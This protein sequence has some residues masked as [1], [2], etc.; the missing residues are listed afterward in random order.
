MALL[1]F[2]PQFHRISEMPSIS[3]RRIAILSTLCVVPI[4]AMGCAAASVGDSTGTQ[5]QSGPQNAIQINSDLPQASVGSQ[6]NAVLL[7]GAHPEA[8]ASIVAGSLP[9]G[10]RLNVT[11]TSIG[12]TPAT[13]GVYRFLVQATNGTSN[14]RRLQWAQVIVQGEATPLRV[15]LSPASVSLPPGGQQQ[16]SATVQGTNNSGV[17]WYASAGSISASGLFVAPATEDGLIVVTA[18]STSNP[19]TSATSSVRITQ[20]NP[21]VIET[22]SI[23]NGEANSPYDVSLS[24]SGGVPPY[25]WSMASGSLPAGIELQANGTLSGT[26]SL[27]GEYPISVRVTDTASGNSTQGFTL[28]LS[29]ISSGN[30]DGPAELPRVYLQTTLADTPAPGKTISVSQSGD[31]QAAL[32]NVSCGETIEL[33]AGATFSG[34]FTL[35]AKAC[36]DQHW[37]IIRTSVSDSVLPSEGTRIT[38]CQAGVPSLPGRPAFACSNPQRLLATL[39]FSGAGSGPI[40]FADGASHYRLIGLEITRAKG[41]KALA[42]LISV[43]SPSDHLVFDRVYVHGTPKD[44]TRRG[45]FLSGSTNV[46]VQNSYFSDFHCAV[47]GSCEDSQAIGGGSGSLPMGPYKITDNFLEAAGE[48]VMFGGGPATATPADIEIRRNHFF[49]PMIWMRGTPG[50]DGL[51]AIVKNHIELKNAQRVLLDSNVMENSWGGFT[52]KGFS[53]VV[54]PKNQDGRA[55]NV[56]PLCRVTDVTIRNVMISHV[57]SAIVLANAVSVSG[58]APADGE[59]YSVHDVIADDIDGDRYAG[60][61]TFVQIST[62]A[63]PLLQHVSINHITAFPPHSFLNVGG[64]DSARMDDFTFTNSVLTSG[65]YPILST[66]AFG[67]NDCAHWGN[68]S[69]VISKCFIDYTFSHNAF[70]ETSASYPPSAWPAGN[71][72]YS[73]SSIEFVNYN[74]GNGGD[75]HLLPGSPGKGAATDGTDLGA[76]VDGVLDAIAGVR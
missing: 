4:I 70:L 71:F 66:G 37:I 38:P 76:N 53:I 32:N 61:G 52:Q 1:G 14:M 13:V 12:G 41:G 43:G 58:G 30:F 28:S 68:L 24:A 15:T 59:R 47:G 8:E 31:L 34:Q 19:S 72:F 45:L 75:Y 49:K 67:S 23:P 54:T 46:A 63:K 40:L 35:P 36:D 20:P 22:S 51:V 9:P 16:F 2:P 10:L 6:Y 74:G 50:F 48:N 7:L 3:L 18:T 11:K 21:L 5:S 60:F 73:N 25:R 39:S 33:Q 64:P 42:S 65:T 62:I 27:Q 57:G 69:S 17:K 44:E 26:S 56:C 29:A 55:G